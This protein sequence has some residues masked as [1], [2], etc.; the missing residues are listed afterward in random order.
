MA[1]RDVIF[2]VTFTNET[3][4][5]IETLKHEIDMLERFIDN[6]FEVTIEQ[7]DY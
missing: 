5:T 2:T 4:E 1:D 6:D 7:V 3:E